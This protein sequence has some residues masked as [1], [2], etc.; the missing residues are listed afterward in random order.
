M[1]FE[2]AMQLFFQGLTEEEA[3]HYYG[4]LCSESPRAAYEA[5]RWTVS[6]D[7]T[8]VSGPILVLGA[9]LDVLTPPSTSRGLADFYGADY[10]FI[11]GRGHN[12]LLEPGWKETADLIIDWLERSVG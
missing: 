12:L 6:V 1:P 3:R 2:L 5:T 8:R 4:L 10:R 11:R 7:K 9:E